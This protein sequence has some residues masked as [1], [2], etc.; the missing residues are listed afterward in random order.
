MK[1]EFLVL[2]TV[3]ASSFFTAPA[4]AQG[5][6][7]TYQGRLT[8]NGSA[9]NGSY[10]LQFYLRDALAGG[11]A[12]GAT[13]TRAPVAANNGLF[14]VT[15]DFGADIFNGP[16]R[17]LEIGARTNGSVAGYTILAPRQA[18]TPTP[19]AITASNLSG[20]LPA[21]QLSGTLP[22]G[23]LAG[24]YSGAVTFSNPGNNFSGNFTGS[25]LLLTNLDYRAIT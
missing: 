22:A 9:A 23:S 16:G 1:W 21:A 14:T 6:V 20:K 3:A 17:W 10:D 12:V 25:G 24:T 2:A 13:N 15:L 11:N 4:F 5:T 18:L 19:Y 7:F 8:D